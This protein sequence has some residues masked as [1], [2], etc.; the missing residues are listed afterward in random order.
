M[1]RDDASRSLGLKSKFCLSSKINTMLDLLDTNDPKHIRSQGLR[2]SLWCRSAIPSFRLLFL[3]ATHALEQSSFVG[4]LR[5]LKGSIGLGRRPQG[6]S[7]LGLAVVEQTK[8]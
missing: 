4:S 5:V 8:R 3:Q 7:E 1:V 6:E 2:Q